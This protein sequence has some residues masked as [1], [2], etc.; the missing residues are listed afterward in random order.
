M[1]WFRVIKLDGRIADIRRN[2][3]KQELKM[4]AI[5]PEV[6]VRRI[7]LSVK[8]R[9]SDGCIHVFRVTDLDD[10]LQILRQLMSPMVHGCYSLRITCDVRISV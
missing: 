7:Q 5:K 2:R 10:S 9:N 4:A 1:F 3:P 8:T 6:T